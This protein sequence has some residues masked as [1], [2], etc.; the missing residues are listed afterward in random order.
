MLARVFRFLPDDAGAARVGQRERLQIS[1]DD[2]IGELVGC[3][4]ELYEL[5]RRFATVAPVRHAAPK[6]GATIPARAAA[7]ASTSTAT[8]QRP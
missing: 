2:A 6:V 7:D 1:L 4:A 5:T 3:V 8:V